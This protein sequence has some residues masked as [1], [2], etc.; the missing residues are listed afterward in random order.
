M[1]GD[2]NHGYAPDGIPFMG[3]DPRNDRVRVLEHIPA[4]LQTAFLTTLPLNYDDT[5]LRTIE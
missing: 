1:V 4:N 3:P 2:L 5:T